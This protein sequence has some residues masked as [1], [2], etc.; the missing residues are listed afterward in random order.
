M[1]RKKHGW[2]FWSAWNFASFGISMP[3]VRWI[4]MKKGRFYVI[5]CITSQ[6]IAQGDYYNKLEIDKMH[7][8]MKK[9]VIMKHWNGINSARHLVYCII[10]TY[11]VIIKIPVAAEITL[12]I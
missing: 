3:L 9:E 7:F 4:E 10:P 1:H 11:A 12:E 6:G 5:Y 2:L 8:S